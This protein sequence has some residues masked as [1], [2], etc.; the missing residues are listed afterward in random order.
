MHLLPK[1]NKLIIICSAPHSEQVVV[2]L[3]EAYLGRDEKSLEARRER[4]GDAPWF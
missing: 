1:V 2:N 4:T 3:D